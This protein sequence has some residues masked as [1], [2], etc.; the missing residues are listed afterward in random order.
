LLLEEHE[1]SDHV[2]RQNVMT[3]TKG[4]KNNSPCLDNAMDDKFDSAAFL[5]QRS[6]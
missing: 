4:R 6:G 1:Q 3:F 5:K 2:T